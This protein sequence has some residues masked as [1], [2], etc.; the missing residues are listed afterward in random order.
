MKN[1][2]DEVNT[3]KGKNR[4][5]ENISIE[6]IQFKENEQHISQLWDNIKQLNICVIGVPDFFF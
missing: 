1:I 6:T 3:T 4:E 5:F 2:V